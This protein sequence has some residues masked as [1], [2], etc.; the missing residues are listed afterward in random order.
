MDIL[1]DTDGRRREL[2]NAPEEGRASVEVSEG[3]VT[4]PGP[5]ALYGGAEIPKDP[6]RLS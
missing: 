3:P 4:A 6:L 1:P 5:S 2:L